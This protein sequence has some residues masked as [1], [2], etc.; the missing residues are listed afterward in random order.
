M[1]RLADALGL[2][3]QKVHDGFTVSQ[4]AGAMPVCRECGALVAYETQQ[5]HTQ[6]HARLAQA[7]Q[8]DQRRA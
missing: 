6:W 5:L 3:Q 8:Q 2:D 1:S 4:R 7:G